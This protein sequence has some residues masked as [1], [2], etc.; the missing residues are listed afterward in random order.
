MAKF[1]QS[2]ID[3]IRWEGFNPHHYEAWMGDGE[4]IH[5]DVKR[6]YLQYERMTFIRADRPDDGILTKA[7]S[8]E[9]AVAYILQ[10]AEH[11]VSVKHLE[12]DALDRLE[13]GRAAI[14]VT[15]EADAL[16]FGL[17]H[18]VRPW[19]PDDDSVLAERLAERA[20][21]SPAVGQPASQKPDS[22][23]PPRV[24]P[25]AMWDPNE[26]AEMTLAGRED[27]RNESAR[28]R[29]ERK[30]AI[31]DRELERKQRRPKARDEFDR[32]M[33]ARQLAR[34]DLERKL[35]VREHNRDLRERNGRTP[36]EFARDQQ[37]RE[38]DEQLRANLQREWLRDERARARYD[39]MAS[40]QETPE[41][42][43]ELDE[44]IRQLDEIEAL[45]DRNELARLERERGLAQEGRSLDAE[46]LRQKELDDR[47]R[48]ILETSR[49]RVMHVAELGIEAP[50]RVKEL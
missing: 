9:H 49:A 6:G 5:I 20:N 8:P 3:L 48:V 40:G 50:G 37:E 18:D 30:E 10:N 19:A 34:D 12:A 26:R 17:G 36:E 44:R 25:P 32:L 42:V 29:Q 1:E 35:D 21:L 46:D 24:P 2:V 38:W 39:R 31:E 47:V 43:H 27:A 15:S 28:D 11:T 33:D 7:Y 23:V 41:R 45:L 13:S 4:K 22:A 16:A 14:L